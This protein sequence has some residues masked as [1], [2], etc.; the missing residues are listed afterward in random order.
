[1]L[2]DIGN[3]LADLTDE[4][5]AMLEAENAQQGPSGSPNSNVNP[6]S[7]AVGYRR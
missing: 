4:L 2:N 3:M 6:A 5:D 1:V 7:R